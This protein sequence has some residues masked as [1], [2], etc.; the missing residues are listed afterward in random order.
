MAAKAKGEQEEGCEW[1]EAF[2]T[3][4]RA[5]RVGDLNALL[6]ALGHPADFPNSL[7]PVGLGLT[8]VPLVYAICWSPF[9]LIEMLLDHA[10][11]P[12]YPDLSGFPSLIAALSTLRGD[13]LDIVCLLPV[14]G[15]DVQ[16][17]G[18]NDW[19]PLHHAG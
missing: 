19:T 18:L 5:F 16:Q 14:R 3:I 15:A 6:T 2:K 12:N 11:N 13:R 9:H 10:C 1:Y 8:E 4:D 7:H 17:R